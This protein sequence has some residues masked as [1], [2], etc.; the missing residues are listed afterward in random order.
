MPPKSFPY[1]FL[2]NFVFFHFLWITKS[3]S[4]SPFCVGQL[5]LG[6]VSIPEYRCYTQEKTHL[7]F[8]R[9]Y[10]FQVASLLGLELCVCFP[11][12]WLGFCLVW[13]QA[14]LV[15]F[16]RLSMSSFMHAFLARNFFLPLCMLIHLTISFLIVTILPHIQ[17]ASTMMTFMPGFESLTV[18][19]AV[20]G[21]SFHEVQCK[22]PRLCEWCFIFLS[23]N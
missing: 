22:N 11:F 7:P 12:S 8:P 5:P 23:L 4:W 6:T 14:G 3:K 21:S 13:V 17:S 20:N 9:S 18:L 1:P 15:H 16:A 10:Q 2:P 19:R